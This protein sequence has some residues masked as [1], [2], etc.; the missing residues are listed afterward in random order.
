MQIYLI[1]DISGSMTVLGKEIIA[2]NAIQS[3]IKLKGLNAEYSGIEF[4][5]K[6]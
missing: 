6:E 2:E 5:N 1:K 4:L 3:L